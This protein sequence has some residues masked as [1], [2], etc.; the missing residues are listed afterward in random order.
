MRKRLLFLMRCIIN[1]FHPGTKF[2]PTL[3]NGVYTM[4]EERR[5]YQNRVAW[6][7]WI[8]K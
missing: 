1:S 5:D 4:L 7:E 3:R 2:F 6:V 8:L